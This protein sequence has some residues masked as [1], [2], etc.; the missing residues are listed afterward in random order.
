[1]LGISHTLSPSQVLTPVYFERRNCKTYADAFLKNLEGTEQHQ[2]CSY[3]RYWHG[4]SAFI[5]AVHLLIPLPVICTAASILSVILLI[6][7]IFLTYRKFGL[8]EALSLGIALAAASYHLLFLRLHLYPVFFIGLGGILFMACRNEKK[9]RMPVFFSLGMLCPYFDSLTAPVITLGLPMLAVCRYD[10]RQAEK[11]QSTES[12]KWKSFL[13]I[14]IGYPAIWFAGYVASWGTKILLTA[15]DSGNLLESIR[16]IFLRAG[17]G[18]SNSRIPFLRYQAV[19]DNFTWLRRYTAGLPRTV[20]FII[21]LAFLV[22][23]LYEYFRRKR[24]CE[25]RILLGYLVIA[26]IPVFIIF[27]TAN[28]AVIHAKFFACRGLAVTAA[29]A[30][31]LLSAFPV[32]KKSIQNQE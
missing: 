18:S 26:L 13:R 15:M 14:Y 20:F 31:M 30:V 24:T 9:R 8:P 19:A 27:C 1:M 10:M 28:H 11:E 7:S 16:Q 3:G 12:G 29:A 22:L 2:P 25:Y 32:K 23:I 5:R 4:H 6:A 21:V 17:F